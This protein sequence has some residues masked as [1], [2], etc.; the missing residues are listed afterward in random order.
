MATTS[1]L[2]AARNLLR[3]ELPGGGRVLC[4]VSGG[5]D[6]MCLLHFLRTWGRTG[7]FTVLAAHFNHRL[8]G[9]AADRDEAFVRDWCAGESIPLFAGSGDVGELAAREG[10]SV[11]EAART[12]RYA[13][14]EETAAREGCAAILTAH[15]ADDNAETMLLNLLRGTG[16]RG[17]AGIPEVRGN[18]LRPFLRISRGELADYAAAHGI[19]HVEDETNQL[20]DAARNVLRHRVLPVLRELNPRAAENMARTAELALR[21]EEALTW[22]AEKLLEQGGTEPGRSAWLPVESCG[23]QP[24]AVVTR[25]ARLLLERTGGHRKDLTAAHTEAV[26]E[27]LRSRP[28]KEIH[29]PYGLTAR[30]E[31]AVLRVCRSGVPE[32]A[33]LRPG[34]PA[35]WN[36]WTLTLLDHPDGEGL[37]L[38]DGDETVAVGPCP[39]GERLTL[40]ETHG[41]GRT[42]KRL[43]LDRGISLAE[44]EKLPAIYLNGRLAAVWRLGADDG[45]CYR[46]TGP[47]RFI[48]ILKTDGGEVL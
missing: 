42:V 34:V 38:R 19:P 4:A 20:D 25:A 17:L 2:A 24:E 40:P 13:F 10:L 32:T 8:R 9:A 15:H 45:S 29:L 23:G 21:D 28:G 47:V 41:G 6:S 18:I 43:C 35:A 26:L 46:G 37:A 16:I 5:L 36:G 30:R 11:E 48:R 1:E 7:N 44:R 12:L 3:R 22:A 39:P 27:L 14:L 33:E 31:E